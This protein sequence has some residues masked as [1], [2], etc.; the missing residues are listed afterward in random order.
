[1][2]TDSSLWGT[3]LTISSETTFTCRDNDRRVVH[4]IT[5]INLP[6]V[7]LSYKFTT[8]NIN[9]S[10]T[11]AVSL[12]TPEY[13]AIQKLSIIIIILEIQTKRGITGLFIAQCR[14]FKT[15]R[16]TPFF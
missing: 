5:V 9:I 14:S 15:P 13:S 4:T 8:G 7:K 12:G 3:G 16:P 1:M 11:R 10:H 6:R 2:T